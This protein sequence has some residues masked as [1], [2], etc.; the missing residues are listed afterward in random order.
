MA[1]LYKGISVISYNYLSLPQTITVT[2][3]K[4][5]GWAVVQMNTT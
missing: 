4:Q 5:I 1:N 3:L 2:G